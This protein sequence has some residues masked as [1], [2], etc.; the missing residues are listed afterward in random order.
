MPFVAAIGWMHGTTPPTESNWAHA[1]PFLRTLGGPWG[2]VALGVVVI[3]GSWVRARPT[4]AALLSGLKWGAA[5]A[6]AAAV[7]TGAIRL[8]VGESLPSFIPPEESARPGLTLGLAAGVGEE[9]LFRLV[10]L[11]IAYGLLRA[12]LARGSAIALAAVLVGVCFAV[13]H[14]LPPASGPVDPGHFA[15]RIV[16]PGALMSVV[17]LVRPPSFMIVAHASAHLLIPFLFV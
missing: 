3:V 2:C 14:E 8:A 5:G 11:P 13:G 6:V 16:L 15:T 12:K 17:A 9:L 1:D 4:R 7:V 10:L